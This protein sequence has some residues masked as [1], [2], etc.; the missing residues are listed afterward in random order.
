MQRV[1][2]HDNKSKD[3]ESARRLDKKRDRLKTLRHDL[4]AAE[5]SVP[6]KL[7]E[8]CNAHKTEREAKAHADSVHGGQERRILG[9]IGL[10][11]SES[12]TVDNDQRDIDTQRC[13]E[14]DE[15]CLHDE[16]DDRDER[17]DDD[18]ERRQ[19]DLIWDNLSHQRD[20]NIGDYENRDRAGSHSEGIGNGRA[21]GERRAHA[22][23]HDKDGIFLY[24]AVINTFKI[25]I[26]VSSP[27]H[28]AAVT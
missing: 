11:A 26:H 2:D 4:H 14:F 5:R 25:F 28:S 20:Y 16:L 9:G 12:D 27:L 15:I 10:C 8:K 3:E 19:T 21:D 23:H 13:V 17:R 24:D 18:D 22:E 7:T 6:E 1:H